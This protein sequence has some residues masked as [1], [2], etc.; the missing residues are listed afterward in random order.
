MD[1]R[2]RSWPAFDGSYEHGQSPRAVN[3]EVGEK[4]SSREG[5]LKAGRSGKWDSN[6]RLQ[7]WQGCTLPLSYSRKR[8]GL[9]ARWA[10]PVKLPARCCVAFPRAPY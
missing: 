7:P 5:P 3:P 9:V 6:P 2:P 1:S 4:T 10:E 8:T